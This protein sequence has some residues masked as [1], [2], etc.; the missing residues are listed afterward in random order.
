[1]RAQV[2]LPAVGIAFVLLTAALVL[3]ISVANDALTSAERPALE[4]EATV[5]LSD[6]LVSGDTRLTA[7]T[8]VLREPAV[9]GLNGSMLYSRYGLADDSGATVQLGG[10]TV[11]TAGDPGA[12]TTVERLVLVENRTREAF[13]PALNNSLATT[14]PRRAT[15]V[16]VEIT[17]SRNSTVRAVEA[18]DRT[19]LANE[20][21][22]AG[23]FSVVVSKLETTELW[24]DVAGPLAEVEVRIVYETSRTRKATLA[25]T[26]DA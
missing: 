5:S 4:R 9:S 6:Q 3:G 7:R 11:A 25:V 8:N 18:N 2:E 12:G 22:L 19:V 23:A 14:L 15:N 10:E 1:M 20:S 24:F 17:T 16:T 26:V 13:R 21:G